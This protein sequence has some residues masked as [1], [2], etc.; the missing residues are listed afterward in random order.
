MSQLC[1]AS[2]QSC[3]HLLYV[4]FLSDLMPAGPPF[5]APVTKLPQPG[6]Q[7]LPSEQ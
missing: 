7:T 6:S 4:T 2:D 3:G 1:Q 5:Y